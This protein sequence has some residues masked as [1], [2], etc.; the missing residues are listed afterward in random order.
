MV[1]SLNVIIF[2]VYFRRGKSI[3]T[4]GSDDCKNFID[5]VEALLSKLKSAHSAN[6]EYQHPKFMEMKKT[7]LSCITQSKDCHVDICDC[8]ESSN[9]LSRKIN[10]DPD[11]S[12]QNIRS[13]FAWFINNTHLVALM[14]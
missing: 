7:I 12:S 10:S 11:F 1:K 5:D 14:G 13:D 6:P 3:Q 9:G 4:D 8:K 2:G